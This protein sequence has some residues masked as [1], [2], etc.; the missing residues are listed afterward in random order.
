MNFQCQISEVIRVNGSIG[1]IVQ[2]LNSKLQAHHQ[3]N[4]FWV[5]NSAAAS[6]ELRT[7]QQNELC[8]GGYF[9]VK[10]SSFVGVEGFVGRSRNIGVIPIASSF[11][12]LCRSRRP[13]RAACLALAPNHLV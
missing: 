2:F 1:F 11:N 5:A 6:F 13:F 12:L 8:K 3:S 9:G 4:D 7:Q 10:W